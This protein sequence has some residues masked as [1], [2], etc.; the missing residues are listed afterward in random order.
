MGLGSK[1][2]KKEETLMPAPPPKGTS[3]D[4]RSSG[5]GAVGKR[6]IRASRESKVSGSGSWAWEV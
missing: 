6:S 5:T 1:K 4:G 2:K 3:L